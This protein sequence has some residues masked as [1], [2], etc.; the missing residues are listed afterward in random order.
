MKDGAVLMITLGHISIHNFLQDSFY[1]VTYDIKFYRYDAVLDF[2][3]IF[4]FCDIM[5]SGAY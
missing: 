3:Y 1:T 4:K 2:F 5:N